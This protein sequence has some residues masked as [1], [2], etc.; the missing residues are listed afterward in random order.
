MHST[1]FVHLF[2]QNAKEKKKK[3]Q[4]KKERKKRN[5]P[6]VTESP[7]MPNDTFSSSKK[8]ETY[9]KIFNVGE[10]V[11]EKTVTSKYHNGELMFF[12]DKA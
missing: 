10:I 8:S 9:T 6:A 12:I 3:K 2:I 4:R 7:N 11:D 5:I 1:S